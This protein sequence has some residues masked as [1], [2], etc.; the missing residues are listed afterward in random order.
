MG[1]SFIDALITT[2]TAIH[3]V[4][5]VFETEPSVYVY[6]GKQNQHLFR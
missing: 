1:L 3:I 5:T 2:Q 6:I 4:D